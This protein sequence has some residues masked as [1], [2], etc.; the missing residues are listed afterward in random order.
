MHWRTISPCLSGS[1]MAAMQM[2]SVASS[3]WPGTLQAATRSFESLP[4]GSL[5]VAEYSPSLSPK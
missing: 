4:I 1:I 3:D 2:R 5:K